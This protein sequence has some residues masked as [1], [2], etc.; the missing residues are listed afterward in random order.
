MKRM[1]LP[2]VGLLCCS[3]TSVCLGMDPEVK[4]F[5][6]AAEKEI[7]LQLTRIESMAKSALYYLDQGNPDSVL[8]RVD[9]IKVALEEI[10][11]AAAGAPKVLRV[12]M[13][14]WE[15]N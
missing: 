15:A 10:K 4:P 12:P 7:G 3:F 8:E 14:G 1:V 11:I 6:P 13:V 9:R 5:S 2:L